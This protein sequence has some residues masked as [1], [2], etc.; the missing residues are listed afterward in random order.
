MKLKAGYLVQLENGELCMVTYGEGDNINDRLCI[1]GE[2]T[3]FPTNC[4]NDNLQ[5]GETII[6]KVYGRSYNSGAHKLNIDGRELLWDKSDLKEMT[7]EQIEEELG[8]NIII[9]K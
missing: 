3:W 4:L 9:I 2:D 8:Y 6:T 5:Y 1:S 7:K